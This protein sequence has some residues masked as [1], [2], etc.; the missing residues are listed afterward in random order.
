MFF[1]FLKTVRGQRFSFA[2]VRRPRRLRTTRFCALSNVVRSPPSHVPVLGPR[3]RFARRAK[4]EIFRSKQILVYSFSSVLFFLYF[5]EHV[6]TSRFVRINGPSAVTG[7]H[8]LQYFYYLYY[9]RARARFRLH[10][11]RRFKQIKLRNSF[12]VKK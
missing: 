2:G 10:T 8:V 6:R 7:K 11:E 4:V 12:L 1:F 9:C 3:R 5:G